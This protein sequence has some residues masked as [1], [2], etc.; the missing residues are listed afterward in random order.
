MLIKTIFLINLLPI[1]FSFPFNKRQ[2]NSDDMCG[3]IRSTLCVHEYLNHTAKAAKM[4]EHTAHQIERHILNEI[5]IIDTFNNHANY[6][7]HSIQSPLPSSHYHDRFSGLSNINKVCF[8]LSF[9]C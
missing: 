4:I 1:I 2:S 9:L 5:K 6:T 8:L 7:S 3:P